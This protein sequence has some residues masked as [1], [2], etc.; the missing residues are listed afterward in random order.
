MFSL[1][2]AILVSP[3]D[4]TTSSM[5]PA[6]LTLSVATLAGAILLSLNLE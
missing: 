2:A 6:T 4:G 1:P 5:H 3:A